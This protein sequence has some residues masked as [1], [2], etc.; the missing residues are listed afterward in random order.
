MQYAKI[1]PDLSRAEA[2]TTLSEVVSVSPQ[3]CRTIFIAQGRS[4]SGTGDSE[5]HCGAHSGDGSQIISASTEGH[6]IMFFLV[7]P[8]GFQRWL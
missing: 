2:W 3:L 6:L 8:P 1:K 7:L 5:V 4:Y